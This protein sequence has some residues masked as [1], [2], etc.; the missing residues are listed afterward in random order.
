MTRL[1]FG[2]GAIILSVAYFAEPGVAQDVNEL[3]GTGEFTMEGP[4]G[5]WGGA[6]AAVPVDAAGVAAVRSVV[7]P[8]R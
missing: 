8:R 5:R 2:V 3:A 6:A 7:V 4:P 1:I